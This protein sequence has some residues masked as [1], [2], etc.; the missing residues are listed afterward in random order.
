MLAA[1]YEAKRSRSDVFDISKVARARDPLLKLR[2]DSVRRRV[3]YL[4]LRGGGGGGGGGGKKRIKNYLHHV[5]R[6]SPS[7]LQIKLQ[8]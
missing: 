2:C 8:L 1:D 4:L 5:T 6:H 3:V 7:I